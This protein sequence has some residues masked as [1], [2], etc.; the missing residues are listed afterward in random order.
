MARL[1]LSLLGSF[2]V[3]LDGDAVT[4][5]KS[6]KE[7]ALLAYLATE[8]DRPHRRE[9]LAGLLWPQWPDRDAL[10]NLR[11]ALS[12][13]RQVIGDRTAEPPFLL[14]T[15]DTLQFN[16]ASDHR[17]DVRLLTDSA[18]AGRAHPL[19]IEELQRAGAAYQGSFLEGF[20]VNDS[21]GF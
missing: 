9:V 19:P 11:Y 7:R 16:A 21:A 2:R 5:F 14:I 17:L 6:N 1:S 13:L 3:T 4:G 12:N 20:S 8:G 15:H 18:E 10:G